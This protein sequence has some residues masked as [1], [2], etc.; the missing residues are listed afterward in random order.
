MNPVAFHIA[1]GGSFFTGVVLIILAAG[2]ML[3]ERRIVKRIAALL[4]CVGLISV[5][6][7]STPLPY[8]LL[9]LAVLTTIAWYAMTRFDKWKPWATVGFAIA[10]SLAAIWEATHWIAPT[11]NRVEERAVKVIGDSVTAG[12]GRRGEVTWPALLAQEHDV[13]VQDL[14]GA[15][16]TTTQALARAKSS[17]IDAPVVFVEIGGNDLL[18]G[19]SASDF[20]EDLDALLALLTQDDR[21]VIMLELPLP[22]F[23]GNYGRAQRSLAR[24]HGVLLIPKRVFLGILAPE[25]ATVDTIH[26]TS[27]GHQ[28]MADEVWRLLSPAFLHTAQD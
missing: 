19:K 8:W 24:K 12:M 16:F 21:Q 26:L 27:A 7:S 9:G 28:R 11:V 17:N 20:R 25:E 5:A 3:C 23:H 10:W 2:V 4:L 14:S 18:G 6:I 15:G 22:P 1:G 13:A